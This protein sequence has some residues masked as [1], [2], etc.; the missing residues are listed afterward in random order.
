MPNPT[1][2]KDVRASWILPS[3]WCVQSA[4]RVSDGVSTLNC[5]IKI[6][7]VCIWHR[8]VSDFTVFSIFA[9]VDCSGNW[10]CAIGSFI[11]IIHW[12]FQSRVPW[13]TH[14]QILGSILTGAHTTYEIFSFEFTRS[15]IIIWISLVNGVHANIT[16]ITKYHC[17]LQQMFWRFSLMKRLWLRMWIHDDSDRRVYYLPRSDL[18]M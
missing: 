10:W 11:R 6:C 15:K 13:W 16:R 1:R 9:D 4:V 17:L 12:W 3:V 5:W 18:W 2:R 8:I 7:K 14:C